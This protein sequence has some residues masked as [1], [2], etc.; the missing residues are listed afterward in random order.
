MPEVYCV[1]KRTFERIC[2]EERWD[3]DNPPVDWAV[4]SICCNREVADFVLPDDDSH[5][6]SREHPTVLNVEFDDIAEDSKVFDGSEY[7]FDGTLTAVGLTPETAE[8]IVR[9]IEDHN[10][11]NFLVHC[12][13]G[14]SRSQGVVRYIL[15]FYPGYEASNRANPCTTYNSHTFSQLKK[16]RERIGL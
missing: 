7:G 4:I 6:F 15:D 5:W 8:R 10:G 14:K 13:A 16:A 11:M 2:R 1:S 3:D 12:R 9:Y